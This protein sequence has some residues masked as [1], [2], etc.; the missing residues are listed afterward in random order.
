MRGRPLGGYGRPLL[1]GRSLGDS[2]RVPASGPVPYDPVIDFLQGTDGFILDGRD[3]TLP[4]PSGIYP[5]YQNQAGTVAS[6]DAASVGLAI[7][8]SQR[9][10]LG[11]ELVTNPNFESATGWVLNQAGGSGLS[12]SGGHLL[13][14]SVNNGADARQTILTVG[15]YYYYEY[16]V[17]SISGG[18]VRFYNVVETGTSAAAAGTYRG[19]AYAAHA[20]CGLQFATTGVTA[21]ISRFSVKQVLGNPFL[22]TTSGARPTLALVNGK[23][24]YRGDGTDDGM[25]GSLVPGSAVT[26]IAAMAPDAL[27][28]GIDVICGSQDAASTNRC[29]LTLNNGVLCGGWGTQDYNTIKDTSAE[30]IRGSVAVVAMRASTSTVTLFKY[31]NGVISTVYTGAASGSGSTTRALAFLGILADTVFS[32]TFQGDALA[33]AVKRVCTDA[34]TYAAMRYLMS[35]FV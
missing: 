28:S 10:A 23:W 32:N 4:Y 25:F 6:A 7:E 33:M 13:A 3:P 9:G 11:T 8:G 22:Q 24:R 18:T 14:A 19:F 15:K 5:N 2:G 20:V 21:Q 31:I 12:I 16:V 35:R 34:E 30:D 1:A 27:S 29:F 26:L 17:D